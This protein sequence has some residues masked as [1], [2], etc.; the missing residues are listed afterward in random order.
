MAIVTLCIDLVREARCVFLAGGTMKPLEEYIEQVFMAAGKS[1]ADIIP[2]TCG[3]VI[4]PAN[5]LA[6]FPIESCENGIQLEFTYQ[7]SVFI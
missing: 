4:D 2:F 6:V 1:A 3:H 7:V 5:Q